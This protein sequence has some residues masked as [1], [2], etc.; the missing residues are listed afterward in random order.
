MLRRLFFACTVIERNPLK[1]SFNL[2]LLHLVL[3]HLNVI[4]HPLW[5]FFLIYPMLL[6]VLRAR[7]KCQSAWA[8][9]HL[10]LWATYLPQEVI[11]RTN[12][13]WLSSYIS[14]TWPMYHFICYI[15]ATKASFFNT[16]SPWFSTLLFCCSEYLVNKCNV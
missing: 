2:S 5:I 14:C 7:V 3:H 6:V 9:V 13:S 10:L 11:N 4:F 8:K 12:I 15:A 16:S 1:H